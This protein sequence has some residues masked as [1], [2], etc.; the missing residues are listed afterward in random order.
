MRHSILLFLYWYLESN[1]SY[2]RDVT[3]TFFFV[4]SLRELINRSIN[5]SIAGQRQWKP[6]EWMS[7]L[8]CWWWNLFFYFFH[9]WYNIAYIYTAYILIPKIATMWLHNSPWCMSVEEIIQCV[10]NYLPFL[11]KVYIDVME[12]VRY[13]LICKLWDFPFQIY[14]LSWHKHVFCCWK[15]KNMTQNLRRTI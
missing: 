9:F 5:R 3:M 13:C 11:N 1:K 2:K 12:Q 10:C 7:Y 14:F 15:T 8:F 6:L 4:T